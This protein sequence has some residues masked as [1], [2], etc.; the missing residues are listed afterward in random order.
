MIY[1]R[2]HCPE[3][4]TQRIDRP[5]RQASAS[6]HIQRLTSEFVYC[7][8]FRVWW[9]PFLWWGLVP[10]PIGLTFVLFLCRPIEVDCSWSSVTVNKHFAFLLH[11]WS[12]SKLFIAS[13]TWLIWR[14]TEPYSCFTCPKHIVSWW[15]WIVRQKEM[16]CYVPE[17]EI[18]GP[19][20]MS[21]NPYKKKSWTHITSP[22]SSS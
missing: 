11:S 14:S 15:Y 22:S 19:F 4:Y 1:E 9:R 8:S 3:H 10:F 5:A 20:T 17:S 16:R 7:R 13:M 6:L 12:I 21:D 2:I 18:V